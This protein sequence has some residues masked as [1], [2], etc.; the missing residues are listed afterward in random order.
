MTTP[1]SDPEQPARDPRRLRDLAAIVV[2]IVGLTLIFVAAWRVGP[3]CVL[4]VT[5]SA[6]AVLGLYLGYDPDRE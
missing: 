4:F 1:L 6:T 2:L 3:T 5:G